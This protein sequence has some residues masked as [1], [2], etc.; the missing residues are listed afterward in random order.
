MVTLYKSKGLRSDPGNY[1]GIFLLDVAGKILASVIDARLKKLI[2]C[3][4]DSQCG[5]R[6]KRS[7]SHL[8]HVV[9]RAQEACR[10][11]N[12]RSY[13]VFVDFA[14]AF[15]SP[16]RKALWECLEW[17]GC[18]PDLLAVIMAI[19]EDPCGKLCGTTELFRVLRGVRQGCVLGPTL[20]II[21]LGDSIS[22]K[23]RCY[24]LADYTY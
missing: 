4:G 5:F 2:D 7:T 6:P 15:D 18:P 3:V 20:F 12:V 21:L 22:I 13:A 1:R 19:H 11:A 23:V 16:P 8:I 17:A 24:C 10:L 9:R 14:K